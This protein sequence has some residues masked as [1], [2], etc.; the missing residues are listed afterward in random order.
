[1][2]PKRGHD[3]K[4]QLL[5]KSEISLWVDNYD[6]IFSS[7]DPRP[8][9]QK[10]LSDDFLTEAKRASRDKVSGKIELSLLVPSHQ[11]NLNEER[12]IKRRLKD[13]FKHHYDLLLKEYKKLN[14]QG[15][16]F[17]LVGIIFMFIATY[18]YFHFGEK[19]LIISFVIIL[20]EPAG[21]F[22][23]WEGLNL[24]IFKPKNTQ[25]DLDFYKKMSKG[26]ISFLEY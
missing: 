21:W 16:A 2:K 26:E 23:F 5:K 11:R 1:M 4:N 24:I 7:F 18:V 19:D 25:S 22:T 17:V 6:D 10:A 8:Y 12:I 3:S 13:H 20:L 15:I 14:F 9:S